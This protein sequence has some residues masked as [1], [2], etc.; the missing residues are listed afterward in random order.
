MNLNEIETTTNCDDCD[1]PDE[2]GLAKRELVLV[3]L[4]PI[5]GL[6][7]IIGIIGIIVSKDRARKRK[8][9]KSKLASKLSSVSQQNMNESPRLYS[10]NFNRK[11][12]NY[13]R[14]NAQPILEEE[15]TLEETLENPFK[16]E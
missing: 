11:L 1:Y 5:C 12:S 3:I 15:I 7:L 14:G 4:M 2:A 16:K 10:N 9:S 8:R 6:L 13:S